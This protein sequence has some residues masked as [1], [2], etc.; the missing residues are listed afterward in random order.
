[1]I[2][3][4]TLLNEPCKVSIVNVSDT[5]GNGRAIVLDFGMGR[6]SRLA[7][8]PDNP[9]ACIRHDISN[10]TTEALVM[11]KIIT[12][13]MSLAAGPAPTELKVL[14]CDGLTDASKE[15]ASYSFLAVSDP[16]S[17]AGIVGGWITHNRASGIVLSSV[18]GGT[19]QMQARSE[20]GTLRIP[21]GGSATGEVFV[22][23]RFDNA[24]AGLEAYADAAAKANEVKLRPPTAGYCTW[25]HAGAS[26]QEKMA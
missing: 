18:D 16:A 24:L 21:P 22:V 5:L 7:L 26:R 2:T 1:Y 13:R 10:P 9:F 17:Q 23:G 25:Y 4:G 11:D 14:G 8:Y 12:A 20:Y 3:A 6:T 15:R 19:V